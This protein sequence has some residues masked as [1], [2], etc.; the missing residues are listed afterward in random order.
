MF[1]YMNELMNVSYLC[2]KPKVNYRYK[3]IFFISL[4]GVEACL[5]FS[6]LETDLNP[7]GLSVS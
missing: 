7:P 2:A 6:A 5:L 4:F 3:E 1:G